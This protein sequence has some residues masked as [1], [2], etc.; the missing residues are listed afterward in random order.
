MRHRAP[1]LLI[2]AIETFTGEALACAS[3][4]RGPWDWSRMLEGA[5]Q[6]AGLLAG[7]L[8]GGPSNTAVV[9]EYRAVIIHAAKHAGPVRFV[10]R[11]ERRLF[12]FW[13]CRV[14]TRAADGTLLLEGRITVAPGPGD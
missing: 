2:G 3:T 12:R 10:A 6:S 5:A 7:M 14:E 13:R 1:A 9:A 11:L 4:D 8:P